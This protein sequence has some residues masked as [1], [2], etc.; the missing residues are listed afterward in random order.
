MFKEI[1]DKI[2]MTN[3]QRIKMLLTLVNVVDNPQL[4]SL[5][6]RISVATSMLEMLNTSMIEEDTALIKMIN[7]MIDKVCED[8]EQE[9]GISNMKNRMLEIISIT[10]EKTERIST[11]ESILNNINYN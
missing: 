5:E 10:K 11:G 3:D 8:A 1:A 6:L 2:K 9:R 7:A 4:S